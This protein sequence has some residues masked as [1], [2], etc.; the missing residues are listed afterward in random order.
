[1]RVN[2]IRTDI[3]NPEEEAVREASSVLLGGGIVLCPSDTVYGLLCRADDED[4]VSRLRELKGYDGPKPF[5]LI[6]SGVDM[7]RTLTDGITIA[8][9]DILARYWPGP[10]TVVLPAAPGCPVWVTAGD[11][12]VA[13]RHPADPLSIGLLGEAKQPL[14]STSANLAGRPEPLAPDLVPESLLAGVDL[15]LDGGEL[16]PSEPSTVIRAVTGKWELLRGSPHWL[17]RHS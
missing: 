11:G 7:A 2:R 12:S 13:L 14:V 16:P 9:Q 17:A 10:V 15:I 4:A 3:S 5:I 6:V 1:V 8:V